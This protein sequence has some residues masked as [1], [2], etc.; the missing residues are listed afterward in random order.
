MWALF[1]RNNGLPHHSWRT[2]QSRSF[3]SVI[4][5]VGSFRG[6]SK[7]HLHEIRQIFPAS[8]WQ[9]SYMLK[10]KDCLLCSFTVPSITTGTNLIVTS[11]WTLCFWFDC[12]KKPLKPYLSGKLSPVPVVSGAVCLSSYSI[13][14]H[15][16]S[17]RRAG[18]TLPCLQHGKN[19][20]N[21][22][23]TSV[24]VRSQLK[25]YQESK[26]F[27]MPWLQ[28]RNTCCSKYRV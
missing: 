7:L 23:F 18:R 16:A 6:M 13:S 27:Y 17:W 20:S 1:F 19:I 9:W 24:V 28:R 2:T 3:S 4:F 26:G 5:G 14:P 25:R 8:T 11:T 12:W 21:S 10:E 22:S 15:S